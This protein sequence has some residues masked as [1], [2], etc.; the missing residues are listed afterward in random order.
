MRF[1]QPRMIHDTLREPFRHVH[2]RH[3]PKSLVAILRSRLSDFAYPVRRALGRQR[4]TH[5]AQDHHD[6]AHDAERAVL[7]AGDDNAG[8]LSFDDA[9]A[10]GAVLLVEGIEPLDDALPEARAAAPPDRR[11]KQ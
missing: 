6:A 8:Y 3:V 2:G 1:Q 10:G 9:A 4:E 7:A 5:E 11:T